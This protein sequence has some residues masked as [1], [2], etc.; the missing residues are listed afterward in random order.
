M[1]RNKELMKSICIIGAGECGTRAAFALREEG[2]VGNINLING[3]NCRPYERPALSKPNKQNQFYQEIAPVQK[4]ADSNIELLTNMHVTRID[5]QIQNVELSDGSCINYDKL[6]L[7]TGATARSIESNGNSV[8]VMRTNADAEQ[9]YSSAY[10][11]KNAVIIG[12]GLI[13]LELA[14]ELCS[15]G[16]KVTIIEMADRAMAR[17]V[18]LDT[19]IKIV[20][21]HIQEGVSFKF[22]SRIIEITKGHIVLQDG[23]IL[24]SDITIAAIGVVPNITLANKAGLTCENGICVS[25]TF[26]TTDPKIYAAGDCAN[27]AHPRYGN[28]RQETWRNAQEQGTYAALCLLEKAATYTHIPW[29]WSD[30]YDLGLQIAG[31]P[32]NNDIATIRELGTTPCD[33]ATITFY[34]N[35]SGHLS[36]AVGIGKGNK[37]AKDI[38]IA[39]MLIAKNKVLS[40]SDLANPSL[41]L[42]KLLRD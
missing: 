22:N 5:R 3:E 38:R 31:R 27:F 32:S 34:S 33:G 40:L 11:A 4:Y 13:G 6:L 24:P 14:A 39:Q 1:D 35:N 18:P 26:Q 41:N 16:I 23:T 30:Q 7:A 10:Q 36:A 15:K 12:A 19:A 9:I 20:E 28:I 8:L 2:F 25:S 37:V 17:A 42:K 21:R 29:F